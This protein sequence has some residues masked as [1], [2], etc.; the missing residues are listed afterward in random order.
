[1]DREWKGLEPVAQKPVSCHLA[2]IDQI[3]GNGHESGI[4][5]ILGNVGEA[6]VQAGEGVKAPKSFPGRD[7]M[8]IRYVDNLQQGRQFPVN[9]APT[10]FDTVS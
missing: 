3:S 4:G 1:M 2:P 6:S 10:Q 7:Q 5:V 9:L 8:Q